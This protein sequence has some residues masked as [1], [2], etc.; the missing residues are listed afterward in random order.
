MAAKGKNDKQ[1]FESKA[2]QA[3]QT[4]LKLGYKDRVALKTNPDLELLR[5]NE[6]FTQLLKQLSAE[7]GRK[8]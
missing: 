1:A 5:G 6:R 7:G 4:A 3:I 8:K 2:L